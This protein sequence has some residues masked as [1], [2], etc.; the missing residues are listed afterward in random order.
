MVDWPEEETL[1]VAGNLFRIAP[2]VRSGGDVLMFVSE[3]WPRLPAEQA[4]AVAQVKER[5]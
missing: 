2:G 3:Q 1:V 5:E 4:V